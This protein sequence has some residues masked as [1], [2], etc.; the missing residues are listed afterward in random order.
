MEERSVGDRRECSSCNGKQACEAL[1]TVPQLARALQVP[2]S[3]VYGMTRQKKLPMVR[4]GRHIRFKLSAV[5]SQLE[6]N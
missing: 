4:F 6:G 1:L 5:L 2:V 3:S